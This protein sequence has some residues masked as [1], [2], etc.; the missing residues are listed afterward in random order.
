MRIEYSL[1]YIRN[2]F[3][4]NSQ[5]ELKARKLY[6]YRLIEVKKYYKNFQRYTVGSNQK[7]R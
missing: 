7:G 4:T 5:L 6:I 3:S 1:Q 2:V